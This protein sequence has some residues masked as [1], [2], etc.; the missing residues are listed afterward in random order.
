FGLLAR[1]KFLRGSAFDPFGHS[2]ERKQERELIG[3][4]ERTVEELLRA[5]KPD[6]YRTAVALAELP[7]QIRGY[8][9]VKDKAVAKVRE[10]A[11]QLKARL[12]A[13]EIKVVQLFE[14]AA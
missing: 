12:T 7:E 3:E 6:N 9:H 11:R 13:S 14:P 8:G 2:A 1:F 10:Q 5:L 4:Y